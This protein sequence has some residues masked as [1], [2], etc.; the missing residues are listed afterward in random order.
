MHALKNNA[1]DAEFGMSYW[2]NMKLR[3]TGLRNI[4][5]LHPAE[6]GMRKLPIYAKEPFSHIEALKSLNDQE[7]T[8]S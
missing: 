7:L 2:K 8:D 3:C 4:A 1:Y 6:K 5:T